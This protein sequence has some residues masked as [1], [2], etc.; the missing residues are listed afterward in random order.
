MFAPKDTL[1]AVFSK[2]IDG[3]DERASTKVI[4]LTMEE[5]GPEAWVLVDGDLRKAGDAVNFEG[6]FNYT[7]D[8]LDKSMECVLVMAVGKYRPLELVTFWPA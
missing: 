2:H 8:P 1:Y 4:F 7:I 5:E 6:L 3:V